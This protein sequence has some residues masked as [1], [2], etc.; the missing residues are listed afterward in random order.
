MSKTDFEIIR[1]LS[2]R[3]VAGLP[4]ATYSDLKTFMGVTSNQT[5]ADRVNKLKAGKHIVVH[6][7]IAGIRAAYRPKMLVLASCGHLVETELLPLEVNQSGG[8]S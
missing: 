6:R 5:V 1:Y 8:T 3:E 4:G 2:D 7:G